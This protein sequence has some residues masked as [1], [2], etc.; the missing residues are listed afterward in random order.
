MAESDQHLSPD[1][2][3]FMALLDQKTSLAMKEQNATKSKLA[4][5]G[6]EWA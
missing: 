1:L 2:S 4:Q 5:I 6:E 3:R